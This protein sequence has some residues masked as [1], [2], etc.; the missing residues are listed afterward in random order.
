MSSGPRAST[1]PPRMEANSPDFEMVA[2][3]EGPQL[4]IYLTDFTENTPVAGAKLSVSLDDREVPVAERG[5]GVYAVANSGLVGP[6]QSPVTVTVSWSAPTV[7]VPSMVALNV[8]ESSM[9][10]RRTVAK[11]WREKEI[12]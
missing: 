1:V 4:V 3:A 12:A 6:V 7:R 11:P 10:S 5:G 9:P 2:T 8:P